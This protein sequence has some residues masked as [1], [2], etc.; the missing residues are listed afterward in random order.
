MPAHLNKP[1]K[2]RKQVSLGY[3]DLKKEIITILNQN[4]F[5]LKKDNKVCYVYKQSGDQLHNQPSEHKQM[6]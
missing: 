1:I 6:T 5:K 3:N 2:F 4:A